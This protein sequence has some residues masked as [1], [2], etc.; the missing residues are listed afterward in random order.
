MNTFNRFVISCKNKA[1]TLKDSLR[2]KVTSK[3]AGFDQVVIILIIVAIAAGVLGAF[4]I[5][6]K[7]DLLDAFEDTISDSMSKWFSDS[8]TTS[9]T[10]SVTP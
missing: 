4:Y 1:L 8:T 5:W 3:E 6:A 2:E 10:T 7:G 9:G